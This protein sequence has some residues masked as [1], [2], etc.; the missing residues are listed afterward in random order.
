MDYQQAL[1]YIYSF[2]NF[3]TIPMSRD[4]AN[5][6]LRRMAELMLRLGNPHQAVRSVHLTGTKGKGST[7]AMIASVLTAAGYAT[8]LNTSPHLVDL[9]ERI[10]IDGRFITGD[11]I[12]L[13][14]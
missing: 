11:S 12:W 1:D 3:E 5:F 7:A 2:V 6:D 10:K 9:R 13:Y 4:A 14:L 8:G